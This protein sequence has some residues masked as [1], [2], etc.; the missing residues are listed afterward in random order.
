MSI[1]SPKVFSPV[2]N[3]S[4]IYWR[5]GCIWFTAVR[6]M[7]FENIIQYVTMYFLV[8][9]NLGMTLYVGR[10]S[11]ELN[12]VPQDIDALV[13]ELDLNNNKI[14]RVTNVSLMIYRELRVIS[15]IYNGLTHIGDGAFDNNAKLEK[16][17]A[18]RNKI[19][20]LPQ[21][22]GAAIGSLKN[23]FI[24]G[25]SEQSLHHDFE[26]QISN[27]TKKLNIGAN[28]WNGRFDAAF[29]HGICPPSTLILDKCKR[30][31]IMFHQRQTYIQ[32]IWKW[33]A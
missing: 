2:P 15:L 12:S 20:Q 25:C 9:V 5:Y 21:S 24:L 23:K 7:I 32:L 8:H 27:S 6:N 28:K 30:F 19:Q 16:I 11:Q 29:C 17:N 10:R 13:T 33:M 1:L 31:L 26:P 22:C 18:N 14:T 4:A 3:S